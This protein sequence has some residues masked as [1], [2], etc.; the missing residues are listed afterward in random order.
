MFWN[1]TMMCLSR[2]FH[3]LFG[4]FIWT[5][6][7]FSSG[8]FYCILIQLPLLSSVFFLKMIHLLVIM[9]NPLIL[10]KSLSFFCIYVYFIYSFFLLY[11]WKFLLN[12]IFW[13]M[14]QQ[15]FSVKSQI[16][17]NFFF[18]SHMISVTTMQSTVVVQRQPQT[19]Q[20]KDNFSISLILYIYKMTFT[21]LT[22]IITLWCI[23]VSQLQMLYILN[24]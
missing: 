3:C 22:E 5:F 19:S 1:F 20:G 9:L 4:L 14:D 15:N 23:Y 2:H 18:T 6:T 11:F 8:K 17:N 16:V 24:W 21:K 13:L 7:Y 10:S 12:S